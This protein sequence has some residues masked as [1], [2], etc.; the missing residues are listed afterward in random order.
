MEQDQSGE[1][2]GGKLTRLESLAKFLAGASAV[3]GY[4]RYG[5]A[6]NSGTITR[7]KSTPEAVYPELTA[8]SNDAL[9]LRRSGEVD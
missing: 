1:T 5:P 4:S 9:W 3:Q 7:V 6:I 2:C 8:K